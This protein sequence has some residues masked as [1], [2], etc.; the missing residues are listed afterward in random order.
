LDKI[1]L[2]YIWQSQTKSNANK[3]Y[4]ILVVRGR[5]NGIESQN[6]FS[7]VRENISLEF[8]CEMKNDWVKRVALTNA[9]K[10]R[11]WE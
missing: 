6:A 3:I 1:G 5:C 2:A 9:Q 7:N 11:E 10:R 8:Y 4:R